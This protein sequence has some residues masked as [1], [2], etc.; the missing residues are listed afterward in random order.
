MGADG[1]EDIFEVEKREVR[2]TYKAVV[3]L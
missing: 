1:R 3:F 2:G